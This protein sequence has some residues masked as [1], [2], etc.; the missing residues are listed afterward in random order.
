MRFIKKAHIFIIFFALAFILSPGKAFSNP[1]EKKVVLNFWE[2]SAGEELMRS[3]LDKFERENPGIKVKLQQLTWDYGFEKIVTAIAAGNAPDVCEL[4]STWVPKFS[5]SG[6]L[7]DV[8]EDMQDIKD[9][10]LLWEPVTYKERL[11]GA[12]WLGGTRLMFYNRELFDEAG[13]NRNKAPA[14]WGELLEAAKRI[15]ALGEDIYGFGIFAGE[16]YSPWQEFLPFAWSNNAKILNDDFSQVLIDSPEFVEAIEFYQSLI[17]YS[18]I[19][20]QSQI[21]HLFA[22]GKVGI[23][24]SGFWNFRL[25]PRLNPKLNFAAALLPKPSL[26][27]G[28]SAAFAGGEVFVILSKTKHPKE[29]VKLIK[30][31]IDT[32]NAIE[33]VKIQQN[34]VPTAKDAI[35]HPYY[36]DHPDQKLFFKQME[37]AVAPP[38]HPKWVELEAIFNKAVE[39][40]VIK[41]TPARAL[42][43]DT[44]KQIEFTLKEK[45]KIGR[46]SDKLI[47][48]LIFGILIS[49][50]I[51][52]VAYRKIKHIKPAKEFSFKSNYTTFI[53]LSPWLLIFFIFG[54]YPLIYS[55]LISFSKY[56]LLTSQLSFVG[57]KNYIEIL[58]DPG[59]HNALKNTLIFTFGT[60]PFTTTIALFTAVLINRKIPFKQLYQAGLFLPVA[61]SVIVIATIFTYLYAPDGVVNLALEKLGLPAPKPSW[62]MNTKL[63]LPSIMFMA[64]WSSFGYY[65]VLFLA[66]LQT[67][68]D[69]LFEAASIDGA[70]EWQKF[71]YITIPQIRP[72]ILLVLVINTI[73]SLQ[74]FPEI[75]TMTGGGPLGATTTVVFYLYQKGFNNFQMG[76]ASA[77]GYILFILIMVFSVA[78]MKMLRMGEQIVD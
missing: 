40:A 61:T 27:T 52:R 74:V 5:A 48:A 77:V 11:Y 46:S 59:F 76:Q 51:G 30:F 31:L 41:K 33:V 8:T 70:N 1:S 63:A 15:D 9:K 71:W 72:M 3:L 21:N 28:T 73:H 67:I 19:D 54:I 20:R 23:Q 53:F 24:I 2:L 10:F 6:A 18:I 49:A 7:L 75:F 34:V 65:M 47:P 66:G 36:N 14:T 58:K 43:N 29:A 56:D 62:L 57:L 38:S 69:S 13:L 60:I 50:I 45:D 4:G 64:I 68:P 32:E 17:P 39:E 12:P 55:I 26:R 35:N 16:P 42:L 37:T 22:N 25:I 44:K 78:Q